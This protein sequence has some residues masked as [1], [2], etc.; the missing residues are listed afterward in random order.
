MIYHKLGRRGAASG[1]PLAWGGDGSV[2]GRIC[3]IQLD[4]E[5]FWSPVEEPKWERDF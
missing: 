5:L 3:R 1:C 2:S 4:G